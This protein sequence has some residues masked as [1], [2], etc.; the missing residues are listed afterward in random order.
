M[1]ELGS[2]SNLSDPSATASMANAAL[3]LVKVDGPEGQIFRNSTFPIVP[4]VD[5]LPF[6][7][8]NDVTPL[9]RLLRI[10]ETKHA[11]S[12]NSNFW[13]LKLLRHILSRHRVQRELKSY[14]G[15][16]ITY[17]D[18]IRPEADP[19]TNSNTRTYIKIFALLILID[20]G[21]EIGNFVEA[22]VSDEDLPLGYRRHDTV[23]YRK[24]SPNVILACFNKWKSFIK[25]YFNTTQWKVVT[26][27]LALGPE[28]EVNHYD[29]EDNTILPWIEQKDPSPPGSPSK[30]SSSNRAYLNPTRNQGREGG[31]AS[32]SCVQIDPFSHG[33]QSVLQSVS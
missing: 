1:V 20:R 33:F 32:V 22:S 19:S 15:N 16:A 28:N 27:Y 6:I 2:F 31:Y 13:S 5:T 10:H 11:D 12:S 14:Q 21:D 8:E 18:Q 23:L 29:L 17:L 26:P 7:D 9:G 3:P 24:D 4:I 25:D 30:L